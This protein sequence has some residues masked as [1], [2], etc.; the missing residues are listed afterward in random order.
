MVVL[1]PLES[2]I[3]ELLFVALPSTL[4]SALRV[5]AYGSISCCNPFVAVDELFSP[6][7]LLWNDD[8]AGVELV[9]ID[10]EVGF[11]ASSI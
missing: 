2:R 3:A 7:Y 6:A 11:V 5:L 10:S 4:N 8:D 9:T 1:A